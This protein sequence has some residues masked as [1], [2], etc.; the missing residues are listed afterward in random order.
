MWWSLVGFLRPAGDSA[1]RWQ[2][3]C[4][5]RDP[6]RSELMIAQGRRVSQDR[7]CSSNWKIPSKSGN[8][9]Q[10]ALCP[11]YLTKK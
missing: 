7:S 11:D 5:G 4:R 10:P 1:K 9:V 2:A 3:I 6:R 8:T